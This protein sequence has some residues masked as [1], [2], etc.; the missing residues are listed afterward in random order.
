MRPIDHPRPLNPS[1]GERH[2]V[3]GTLLT[4]VVLVGL[5]AAAGGLIAAVLVH[6]VGLMTA[7]ATGAS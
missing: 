1:F 2:Q 7:T 5:A 4:L 6:V 3:A